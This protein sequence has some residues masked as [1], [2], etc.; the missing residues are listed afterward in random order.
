MPRITGG[1]QT[2]RAL[3]I[4]AYIKLVNWCKGLQRW[5]LHINQS[6]DHGR[7]GYSWRAFT[8]G[9]DGKPCCCCNAVQ[10]HNWRGSPA[11]RFTCKIEQRAILKDEWAS[12]WWQIHGV[13]WQGTQIPFISVPVQSKQASVLF[14]WHYKQGKKKK[15]HNHEDLGYKAGKHECLSVFLT[16]LCTLTRKTWKL[17][18]QTQHR[19]Y[20]D[21]RAATAQGVGKWAL[22]YL[23]ISAQH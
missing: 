13:M 21:I 1:V 18:W 7:K 9:W 22:Q 6:M 20:P 2:I 23:H 15:T 5:L 11:L 12:F 8:Q 10:Q 14:F 3:P 4:Y 19:L 16:A 17:H